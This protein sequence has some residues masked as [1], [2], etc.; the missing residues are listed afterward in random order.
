[1]V[2]SKVQFKT[3]TQTK[4]ANFHHELWKAEMGDICCMFAYWCMKYIFKEVNER[5]TNWMFCLSWRNSQ[6][7]SDYLTLTLAKQ[8]KFLFALNL[9]F[10]RGTA[11]KNKANDFELNSSRVSSSDE[12]Q[13]KFSLL[14][15]II[16]EYWAK[17]NVYI[18][19][20]TLGCSAF[21]VDHQNF[22][23]FV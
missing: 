6:R 15:L 10:N 16:C 22:Y 11:S 2:K 13:V 12:K 4:I 20:V 5:K 19:S 23:L 3:S 14:V 8:T 18:P 7:K 9:I 1:M 21:Y 17:T